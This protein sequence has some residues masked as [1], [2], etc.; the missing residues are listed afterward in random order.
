MV[1]VKVRETYDLQ[2]AKG[3]MTLIGIHTPKPDIIKKNYPGLLMQC[4]SYRPVSCDVR[5][6]CA[7]ML[8]L[9]PQGVGLDV[10]DVAPEDVFNPILYKAMSNKG[11][12]QLEAR[13]NSMMDTGSGVDVAGQQAFVDVD[14]VIPA[15]NDE[16]AMYYALLANTHDWKHASA[17][18]GLT[19]TNL[20]PLVYEMVYNVG[21]AKDSAEFGHC[22][23]TYPTNNDIQGSYG[24]ANVRGILGSAKPMPFIPCTSYSYTV[25]TKSDS[26]YAASGFPVSQADGIPANCSIDVP[27][28]P[29]VCGCIIIPPSRLHELFFRMVCEW[30]IEFSSIRPIS[31][32]AN[33]VDLSY[34]GASTHFQNYSYAKTKEAITGDENTMLNNDSTM[35]S[36]NVDI[37]KVM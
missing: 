14:T 10:G 32:L 24:T 17:Q 4:K 25:D 29:V 23:Y 22:S 21:D 5:I 1:F 28:I 16:F 36:S 15:A 9:D 3:K 18:A 12:S 26:G 27:Y 7:S 37:K 11:M 19:M 8:P 20:R 33:W 30:T 35:V 13:I 2:T 6:A 34:Y 31:E